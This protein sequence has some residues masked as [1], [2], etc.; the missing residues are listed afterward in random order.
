MGMMQAMQITMVLAFVVVLF[1]IFMTFFRAIRMYQ[2]NKNSPK[3]KVKAVVVAKDIYVDKGDRLME[4]PNPLNA[5]YYA[6]FEFESGDQMRFKIPRDMHEYLKEGDAG[7]LSMQGTKYLGFD[8]Q[9]NLYEEV[10]K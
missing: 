6:T 2:N 9:K 8:H 3:L 10:Q 4:I 7:I 5:Q 1:S